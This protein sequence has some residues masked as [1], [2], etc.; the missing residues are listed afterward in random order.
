M[1]QDIYEMLNIM[2]EI[3]NEIQSG[4]KN[5]L[6]NSQINSNTAIFGPVFE[7]IQNCQELDHSKLKFI[8]KKI[9]LD[10]NRIPPQ[11]FSW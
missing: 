10:E 2:V 7:E 4:Q 9:W 11:H 6:Q 3:S 1:R 8:V 5:L